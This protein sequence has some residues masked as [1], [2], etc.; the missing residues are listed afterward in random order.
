MKTKLDSARAAVQNSR[1][2]LEYGM[3]RAGV[4]AQFVQACTGSVCGKV[5][6][7][8]TAKDQR[9]LF[10]QVIGR[11]TIVVD[12]ANETVSNRVIVCFGQDYDYRNVTRWVDL[13]EPFAM[14]TD[15]DFAAAL[16]PCGK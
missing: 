9:A 2:K 15:A 12:G 3:R 1:S 7:R 10:G 16:G 6:R 4:L 11:G 8:M 14:P 13:T 5:E